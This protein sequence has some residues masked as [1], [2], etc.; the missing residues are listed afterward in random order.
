VILFIGMPDDDL[1]LCLIA[2]QYEAA[3]G[4]FRRQVKTL[5]A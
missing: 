3:T 2:H 1:A 5:S 4:W